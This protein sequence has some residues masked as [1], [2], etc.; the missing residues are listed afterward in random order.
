M[1]TYLILRTGAQLATVHPLRQ[2]RLDHHA[3][4]RG[5]RFGG[6]AN[7]CGCSG[8]SP[9]SSAERTRSAGPWACVPGP[10][11]TSGCPGP[12]GRTS[13]AP[14]NGAPPLQ[15]CFALVPTVLVPAVDP[16][17][18]GRND[19]PPS[20]ASRGGPAEV[21]RSSRPPI[22]NWSAETP[23]RRQNETALPPL[24]NSWTTAVPRRNVPASEVSQVPVSQGCRWG[25][26][27]QAAPYCSSLR[28]WRWQSVR[29]LRQRRLTLRPSPPRARSRP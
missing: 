27:P 6:T 5:C 7:A 19:R 21:R 2:R 4:G 10:Q 17:L 18:A 1:G 11:A 20:L 28:V 29:C 26:T 15:G 14:T 13:R 3:I 12:W 9:A 23:R 16:E 25:D 22:S 8:S 24:A